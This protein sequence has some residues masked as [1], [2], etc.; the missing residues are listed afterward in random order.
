[1]AAIDWQAAVVEAES[2]E[3]L[4]LTV[5]SIGPNFADEGHYNASLLT[6]AGNLVK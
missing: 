6:N 3:Q 5:E 2:A 4:L 1:M